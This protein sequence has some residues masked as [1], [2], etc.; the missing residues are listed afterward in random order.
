MSLKL[1]MLSFSPSSRQSRLIQVLIV[2]FILAIALAQAVPGYLSGEW[3]WNT[4]PKLS[5]IEQ[6][7]LVR[8]QGLS[9]PGWQSVE[10]QVVEIGG[11]EW[12]IQAIVPET[13]ADATSLRS[14]VLLMLRPQT[15]HRDLPQ[16]DWMDI[17][18]V[19]RWTADSQRQLRFSVQNPAAGESTKPVHVKARFLRGWS[20]QQTYAVV[21]WYAWSDGG[22]PAPGRW[23]WVDQLSQ[24]RD[25]HRMPWV[26][27]SILIPIKPL[28]DIEQ[29]RTFAETLAETVQSSLMMGALQSTRSSAS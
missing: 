12:S 23:F 22:N 29:S 14:P 9:L 5:Q 6:L 16:V 7:R 17:N 25:R 3:V 19:Q 10:Q 27:V 18:G 4:P 24:W 13:G 8:D 20:R 11:H 2:V 21:Q 28:G 1:N 15:W 26:A